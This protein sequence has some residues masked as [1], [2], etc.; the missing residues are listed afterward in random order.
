MSFVY[1]FCY[2]KGGVGVVAYWR[3]EGNNCKP[4]EYPKEMNMKA[5]Q[6]RDEEV[7]NSLKESGLSVKKSYQDTDKDIGLDFTVIQ[8]ESK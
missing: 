1:F 4:I 7:A 8:F 6:H 5:L 3:A 2:S